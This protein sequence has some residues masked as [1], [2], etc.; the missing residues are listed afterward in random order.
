MQKYS[1]L[2]VWRDSENGC[3]QIAPNNVLCNYKLP[4][5]YFK[6]LDSLRKIYFPLNIPEK[7]HW[8]HL[9]EKPEEA[10]THRLYLH[11]NKR[12]PAPF[13]H[14]HTNPV[15]G[16]VPFHSVDK[17]PF[18]LTRFRNSYLNHPD[19][20]PHKLDCFFATCALCCS[21][22]SRSFFCICLSPML[23]HLSNLFLSSTPV[24]RMPNFVNSKVGK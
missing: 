13:F 10:K 5:W 12:G 21:K 4:I 7:L 8:Q 17:N 18:R 22:W 11:S 15:L 3:V 24:A 9:F 20:V 14:L 23:V 19:V 6:F 16:H 1:I 2:D